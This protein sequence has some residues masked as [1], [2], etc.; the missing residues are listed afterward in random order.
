MPYV[1]G[2]NTVREYDHPVVAEWKVILC[3]F[4]APNA[5][6]P[7][8]IWVEAPTEVLPETRHARLTQICQN[9]NGIVT[10]PQTC[11]AKGAPAAPGQ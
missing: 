5:T 9:A 7:T 10:T 4:E 6:S 1:D 11:L 2:D 3:S 8:R